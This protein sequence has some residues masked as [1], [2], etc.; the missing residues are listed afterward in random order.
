LRPAI[1]VEVQADPDFDIPK[2]FALGI[3]AT[4]PAE[5]AEG[6][7][8]ARVMSLLQNSNLDA[9]HLSRHE[10]VFFRLNISMLWLHDLLRWSISL[11]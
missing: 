7:F 4:P 6:S 2:H 9:P 3:N 10:L 11:W 5:A 1:E 8:P